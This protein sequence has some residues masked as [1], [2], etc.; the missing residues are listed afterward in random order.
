MGLDVSAIN[1]LKR[2]PNE[3]VPYDMEPYT[4]QFY[5][6]EQE[7]DTYIKYIDRK[8]GYFEEYWSNHLDPFKTGYY[9]DE[10]EAE[11]SFRAGSYGYYNNWRKL[12]ALSIGF[13]NIAD[14]W[15]QGPYNE[16]I[17]FIELLDFSD[18][19]GSIGPM[20]SEKLYNDFEGMQ[21]KVFEFIDNLMFGV[22]K[23][24]KL[25]MTQVSDFKEVYKDWKTAFDIARDN[26]LVIL[27]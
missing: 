6:W 20:V 5:E 7:E 12:L 15:S 19:D 11:H 16:D 1:G 18:A 10:G 8:N 9:R 27:Q 24:H 13:E 14:I 2:I 17:P 4:D 26:G 23:G 3:E 25:S 21:D 22:V